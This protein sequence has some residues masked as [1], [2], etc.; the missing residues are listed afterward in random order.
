MPKFS[1]IIPTRNEE[2]Y[3]GKAL[4][5]VIRQTVSRKEMEI[6]VCDAESSDK[7]VKTARKYADKIIVKK[8][9]NPAQGRNLGA[10]IA[11]GEILMF[12]DA[13]SELGRNSLRKINEVIKK[14]YVAGTFLIKYKSSRLIDSIVGGTLNFL[15]I[16]FD[17]FGMKFGNGNCIFIKKKNF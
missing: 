4:K 17:F 11:K 7:T 9:R 2:E 14:G 10:K 5:S 16:F 6:I 12:L 8:T 13:D 15:E 3:V 1:V